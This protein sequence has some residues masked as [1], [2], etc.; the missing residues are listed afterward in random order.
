MAQLCS[1]IPD[2]DVRYLSP[3][4]MT[5]FFRRLMTRP[6]IV[7]GVERNGVKPSTIATYRSYL[8]QFFRWLESRGELASNPFKTMPVP[9]V[10]F[11]DRKYLE[12]ATVERIFSALLLNTRWESRFLRTRNLAIFATLLYTGVRR[13]ELLGIHVTDVDLRRLELSVRGETS[14]SRLRRV[15]PIASSLCHALEDYLEERGRLGLRCPS[16]FVSKGGDSPLT[17][18]GLK[19]LTEEVKRVS[20]QRFHVHQFRHTFAVNF[21][22]RGGD[23]AKLRQLMGHTD[24]RMT[25][26]Y[27]RCLPISSLRP[28]IENLTLDTLL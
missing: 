2:L 1:L 23:V 28:S 6:R 18:S 12:R 15:V 20:G 27:L 3:A 8:S 24:I 21:L 4:T 13:G 9:H 14:K 19:H 26:L 25:S 10:H 5:E 16:V 11:T 17:S 7:G 22:N